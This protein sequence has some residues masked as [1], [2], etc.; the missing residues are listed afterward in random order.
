MSGLGGVLERQLRL[1]EASASAPRQRIGACTH[2]PPVEPEL[3]LEA[4]SDA[5]QVRGE[6]VARVRTDH[7]V[8]PQCRISGFHGFGAA[9]N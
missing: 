3:Q 1:L 2:L 8:I 4:V 7:R 5:G 6:G 9:Q